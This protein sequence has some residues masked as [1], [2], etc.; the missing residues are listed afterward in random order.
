MSGAKFQAAYIGSKGHGILGPKLIIPD[1][2]LYFV[3]LW[4]EN[5]AAYLTGILNAPRV[6]EAVSAYSPR[7]SLGANVVEHLAIPK[8]DPV[9]VD[10]LLVAGLSMHITQRGEGGNPVTLRYLDEIVGRVFKKG[11]R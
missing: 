9:D 2:K 3:P 4:D 5:E 7:L 8:Y 6:A 1:H 11:R 10:H